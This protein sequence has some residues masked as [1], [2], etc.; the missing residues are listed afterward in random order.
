[1]IGILFL[2][3][4]IFECDG[5]VIM[6]QSDGYPE[7]EEVCPKKLRGDKPNPDIRDSLLGSL[8]I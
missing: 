1:M 5:S 7:P 4:L 2:P 3:Q 8:W 6:A